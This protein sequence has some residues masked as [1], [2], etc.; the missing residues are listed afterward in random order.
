MDHS[1]V[2]HLESTS[3]T[4][5][6]G[7]FF[8]AKMVLFAVVFSGTDITWETDC[9]ACAYSLCPTGYVGGGSH[10]SITPVLLACVC[11]VFG[12]VSLSRIFTWPPDLKQ[13]SV[14]LFVVL[15]SPFGLS[16]LQRTL[17]LV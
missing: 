8:T 9:E 4:A 15:A 11:H 10:L 6:I 12:H 1:D 17:L 2:F 13:S 7:L 3:F 5:L 16:L 14:G